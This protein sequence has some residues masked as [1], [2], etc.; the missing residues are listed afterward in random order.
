[1]ENNYKKNA[2][3]QFDRK[4]VKNET[5]KT[6]SNLILKQGL[7]QIQTQLSLNYSLQ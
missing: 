3:M 6:K 2:G 5:L 1:M 7:Y 4:T